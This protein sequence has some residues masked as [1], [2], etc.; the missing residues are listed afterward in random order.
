MIP[1][2]LNPS[3]KQGTVPVP[4]VPGVFMKPGVVLNDKMRGFAQELRNRLGF[5][6]VITSGVRTPEAQARALAQ[7]HNFGIYGQ[8]DLV[9]ELRAGGISASQMART[10]RDQVARGRYLSRHMRGDALDFR[11][12]GLTALERGHLLSVASA[13]GAKTLDEGDHIHLERIGN[14]WALP[15]AGLTLLPAVTLVSTSALALGLLWWFRHDIRKR[16]T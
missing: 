13:M 5:D 10:L 8:Q 7:D 2:Y 3:Q 15:L 12:H 6:L 9:A 4:G 14:K 1:T 16:L 11:V